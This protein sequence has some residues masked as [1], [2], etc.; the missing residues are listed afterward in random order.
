MYSCFIYDS[1][2]LD[3]QEELRHTEKLSVIMVE[4]TTQPVKAE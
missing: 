3:M 4:T 1:F 2:V